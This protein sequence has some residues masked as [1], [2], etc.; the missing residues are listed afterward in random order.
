[1]LMVSGAMQAWIDLKTSRFE[2][3]SILEAP[4]VVPSLDDV[5]VVGQTIQQR[6]GHLGVHK[7]TRPWAFCVAPL[8][9]RQ[10]PGRLRVL[11]QSHVNHSLT[12]GETLTNRGS[13]QSSKRKCP[14]SEEPISDFVLSIVMA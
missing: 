9:P 5:A 13:N 8:R 11:R 2:S 6:A 10:V 12:S 1:M 4:T 3:R 7:D 14:P